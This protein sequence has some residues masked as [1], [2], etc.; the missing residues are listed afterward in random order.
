MA[1]I[2]RVEEDVSGQH[3]VLGEDFTAG[4]ERQVKAMAN[5]EVALVLAE[6]RLRDPE[7]DYNKNKAYLA[8]EDYTSRVSQFRDKEAV[9]E[10]RALL[11]KKEFT[12]VSRPRTRRARPPPPPAASRRRRCAQF[13]M[14]QLANLCPQDIQ[15]AKMLIPTLENMSD[16]NLD[17]SQLS[18]VLDQLQQLQSYN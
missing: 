3:E 7:K 15:E 6:K 12:E 1:R 11:E 16:R 5:A 10:V 13:E 18:E 4:G 14:A 2:A 9:T 8:S 17:D